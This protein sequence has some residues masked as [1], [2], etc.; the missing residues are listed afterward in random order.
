MILN[1]LTNLELCQLIKAYATIITVEYRAG[2]IPI[3]NRD[4]VKEFTFK[5]ESED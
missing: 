4:G 2:S 5:D 1:D 3:A